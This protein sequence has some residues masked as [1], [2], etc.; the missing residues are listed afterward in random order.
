MTKDAGKPSPS[1]ADPARDPLI[2]TVLGGRYRIDTLLGSGAMGRVYAAEHVL[3]HKPLAVKVLHAEHT[4]RPEIIARFEREAT[5]AANIEHPNVV[6]ATDFGTLTDGTVYLALELVQGKSLRAEVAAAPLGVRRTLHIARQVASGLAAAHARSIVHRDLKPENVILVEKDGDPDFVKVLDFGIAKVAMES[7]TSPLTK[8]GM[9]LGTRD[10][11]APEQALG[12]PVDHRA[13]LYSLGVLMYEMMSRECPYEGA[14]QASILGLQLTKAPPSLRKRVPTLDIPASVEAF[15]MKL[16]AK[17]RTERPE[18]ATAVVAELDRLIAS[19]GGSRPPGAPK[20]APKVPPAGPPRPAPSARPPA[21]LAPA[22]SGA[23]SPPAAPAR[24]GAPS[25]PAAPARSGAPS[26]PAAPARSGAPSPPAA[27]PPPFAPVAP[28]VSKPT[29]LPTDPLPSFTFPPLEEA[30]KDLLAKVEQAKAARAADAQ[31]QASSEDAGKAIVPA[32]KVKLDQGRA[33][34]LV[35][36]R[37]FGPRAKHAFK[38]A[39]YLVDDNRRM[40]PAFIRRPLRRVPAAVIL[41]GLFVFLVLVVVVIGLLVA[42]P[43]EDE[44]KE[45]GRTSSVSAAPA[46]PAA[47]SVAPAATSTA[48]SVEAV[49]LAEK[50]LKAGNLAAVVKAIEGALDADPAAR[51]NDRVAAM[52]GEAARRSASSN[53]AFR[54]LTGPMRGKGAEIVY[55]LAAG[56]KTPDEIRTKAESWLASDAFRSVATP[57]L[58]IAGE[59]RTTRGCK[60]KRALLERAATTGDQRTLDY[61]KILAVKGGCGRRGREDCFPCLREDDSLAKTI[62]AIEARLTKSSKAP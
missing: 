11:M 30:S 16:L 41:I 21:P 43:S 61:L 2:G 55:E 10:Y 47:P 49:A 52:L 15:V 56:A 6:A 31:P 45:A 59:L 12:Q 51:D 42:G 5:A 4:A 20:T 62:A 35:L 44:P 46:T 34:A 24:S 23:P 29:F 9:V 17:E 58:A 54:L 13:D 22:R 18:S 38:E 33:R 25:P 57:P 60:E 50:E 7:G 28:V 48:R 8:V 14:S 40:L 39:T 1:A 37:T 26:P 53:A 27:P 19:L 32:W 36:L 3:M